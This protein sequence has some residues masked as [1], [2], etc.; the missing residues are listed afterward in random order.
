MKA[1][2]F[3]VK[4]LEG[5]SLPYREDAN[6]ILKQAFSAGL[7]SVRFFVDG[8]PYKFDF[9]RQQQTNEVTGD[10]LPLIKPLCLMAPPSPM[11]P[12]FGPRPAF[13]VRV[14]QGGPG[15]QIRAPHP[16]LLGKMMRVSIPLSAKVGDLIFVPI[17][18]KTMQRIAVG[19]AG[20]T[21]CAS[22]TAVASHGALGSGATALAGAAL[23]LVVGGL[24]V[25]GVA[26]GTAAAV[27][28]ARQHPV[29]FAAGA[30][31]FVAGLLAADYVAEHG[32]ATAAADLA[33]GVGDLVEGAGTAAEAVSGWGGDLQ[34]AVSGWGTGDWTE[35]LDQYDWTEAAAGEAD[36]DY[37]ASI[38]DAL[39]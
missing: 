31:A 23:P 6:A 4:Q 29:K 16:K 32:V 5:S 21:G 22:V 28:V 30:G 36:T 33:G 27:H 24:A 17:P 37:V 3:K 38:L 18:S 8:T 9:K 14:P 13:V 7:P 12:Q 15:T 10:V 19:C 25:A 1:T 11:F 35:M 39:F 34:E 26:A 20:F 2:Q